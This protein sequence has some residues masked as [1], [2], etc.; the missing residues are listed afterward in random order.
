MNTLAKEKEILRHVDYVCNFASLGK[1]KKKY[2]PTLITSPVPC[3]LQPLSRACRLPPLSNLL[4]ASSSPAASMCYTT[5]RPSHLPPWTKACRPSPRRL[6][7]GCL[8]CCTT[9]I[10]PIASLLAASTCCTAA[11]RSPPRWLP[12]RAAR[13]GCPDVLHGCSIPFASTKANLDCFASV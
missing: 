3:H 13:N 7:V 8:A 5:T 12:R 2:Y 10:L 6:L 9:A 4:I 11:C 1:K